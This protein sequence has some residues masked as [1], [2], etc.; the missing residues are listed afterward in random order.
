MSSRVPK[1]VGVS[2]LLIFSLSLQISVRRARGITADRAGDR[3][4][5]LQA[6]LARL[7]TC[8]DWPVTLN[9]YKGKSGASILP[10]AE[11]LT[12]V[13]T[14]AQIDFKQMG[15]LNLTPNTRLTVDFRDQEVAVSLIRGCV[16]LPVGKA[17]LY[18]VRFAGEGDGN[19]NLVK[20]GSA[21]CASAVAL[22]SALD[23]SQTSAREADPSLEELCMLGRS[24]G[25]RPIPA[26]SSIT[27]MIIEAGSYI[28]G[29][30]RD[31]RTC[32]RSYI[33]GA[34]A[35]YTYPGECVMN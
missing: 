26:A 11:I 17:Q 15:R 30:G 31:E 19:S 9:G 28:V 27:K 18:S 21:V 29:G 10:G 22:S 32:D 24:S 34:S 4:Q 16:S 6:P 35:P 14:S 23:G 20:S 1:V 33:L 25:K 13:E 3:A 12:P 7:T 8:S 5:S 2:V